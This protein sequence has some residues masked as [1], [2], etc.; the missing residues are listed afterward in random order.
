MGHASLIVNRMGKGC[1]RNPFVVKLC[2]LLSVSLR[3]LFGQFASCR[4]VFLGQLAQ[5][6]TV[7]T[8]TETILMMD[9]RLTIRDSTTEP[10]DNEAGL[11]KIT[12]SN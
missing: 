10:T 4:Y 6:L 9:K 12:V 5:L 11:P 2:V 8:E 3:H 7:L 1:E